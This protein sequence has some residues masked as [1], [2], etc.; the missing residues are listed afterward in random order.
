MHLQTL[1]D[2]NFVDVREVAAGKA[3]TLRLH[4]PPTHL[5]VPVPTIVPPLPKPRTLTPR[6]DDQ[7]PDQV[8]FDYQDHRSLIH[9]MSV[10]QWWK[11]MSKSAWKNSGI[12]KYGLV[13]NGIVFFLV[14]DPTYITK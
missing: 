12:D 2:N 1:V 8:E 7:W 14:Y 3:L 9:M 6:G 13:L 11:R 5:L 10:Q 4:C